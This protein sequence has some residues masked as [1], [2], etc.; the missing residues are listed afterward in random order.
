VALEDTGAT[1]EGVAEACGFATPET[2]RRAFHRHAGLT[3]SA[4]RER[5]RSAA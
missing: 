1:I 5:S 3:P 2:F 4:Y